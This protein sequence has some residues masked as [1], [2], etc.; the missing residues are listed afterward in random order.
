MSNGYP[1]QPYMMA[2]PGAPP[3]PP[4]G[5]YPPAMGFVAPY[6]M[7]PMPGPMP[8]GVPPGV[9]AYPAPPMM[10]PMAPRPI[11]PP[12]PLPLPVNQGPGLLPT[13]PT[14]PAVTTI[15]QPA[16]RPTTVYVGKLPGN[17]CTNEFIESVLRHC[18][19]FHTWNRPGENFGY[20][21]FED[22]DGALRALRL[23][24]DFELGGK[25]LVVTADSST[26]DY[27]AEYQEERKL[28]RIQ[29]EAEAEIA[30][31]KEPEAEETERSQEEIDA[32]ALE[33]INKLVAKNCAVSLLSSMSENGEKRGGSP[34]D[35]DGPRGRSR[36]SRTSRERD[37]RGS[38]RERDLKERE[39]AKTREFRARERDT[40]ARNR[41]REER[42]YREREMEW[43][44]REQN[45]E[46]ERERRDREDERERERQIE[47]ELNYDEENEVR[48]RRSGRRKRAR[49]R[50]EVE[51][52][53]D[54]RNEAMEALE[55]VKREARKLIEQEEAKKRKELEEEENRKAEAANQAATERA[56]VA[57]HLGQSEASPADAPSSS[58]S[59][60][61]AEAP[62][63]SIDHRIMS[64]AR[65]LGFGIIPEAKR[66]R[67]AP[68]FNPEEEINPLIQ[69]TRKKLVPLDPLK[70][71]EQL[72]QEKEEEAKAIVKM[73][74]TDK[75]ALFA[76]PVS[77]EDIEAG[78]I[79]SKRMQPWVAKKIVE[80]LGEEE[81]AL[82]QFIITK[83]GEKMTPPELL[84]Q[85]SVVLAEEAEQFVIKLW[86]MLIFEMLRAQREANP[87][88]TT[89]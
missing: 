46:R 27:L 24:H 74:P 78:S 75:D 85:L 83:M 8:P 12:V 17:S 69:P 23:L 25:K 28:A 26:K 79:L 59:E 51:D 15:V 4:Y 7:P 43:E 57:F 14:G 20:C 62:M 70:S 56:R 35:I 55:K 22:A 36:G 1:Y 82:E 67:I 88:T 19:P 39:R 11:L 63:A 6:P 42:D 52:E 89:K 60:R 38:D 16:K 81:P 34:M 61:A 76:F 32:I 21:K 49:E 66:P 9:V 5:A 50:E 47:R 72:K 54:R 29:A 80:Y 77:W 58:P 41:E 3:V 68:G 10:H 86:R 31:A 48:L 53:E 45:K 40:I 2:P 87:A 84:G 30:G 71:E 44:V 73:I 37:R 18:G 33:N 64:H 13:P 65:K